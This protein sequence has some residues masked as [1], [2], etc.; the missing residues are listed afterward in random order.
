MKLYIFNIENFT[1]QEYEKWYKLLSEEKK[2][3]IDKMKIDKSKKCSVAGEMLARQ[4]IAEALNI[5]CE[6]IKFSVKG[7]GKPIAEGLDIHFNISHCDD[8]VVCVVSNKEIGIDI[9]KIR[10]ISLKIAK[11]ICIDNELEYIFNCEADKV[12]FTLQSDDVLKRLFEV[13]TGKE[14]V[15][16]YNGTGIAD[17]STVDTLNS[18]LLH[19]PVY[20]KGFVIRIASTE[21]T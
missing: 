15:F 10:P 13:W 20:H 19:S 3:K 9:E 18:P 5:S 14:A 4:G 1:Q 7:N 17:F 2:A 11:R 21:S 12:D 6:E 8:M 16:K